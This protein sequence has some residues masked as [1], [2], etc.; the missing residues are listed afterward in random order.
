[1]FVCGKCNEYPLFS[2]A[3]RIDDA[4]VVILPIV[5][6]LKPK[7][8]YLPIAI[9]ADIADRL[10]KVHGEPHIWWVGQFMKYL[11]RI[12]LLFPSRISDLR[13]YTAFET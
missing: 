13:Y 3:G 5:D 11:V 2:T 1:M 8:D 9:P 10:E 4:Q 12:L 7:P 6:I